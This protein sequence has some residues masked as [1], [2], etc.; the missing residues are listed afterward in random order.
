MFLKNKP[1]FYIGIGIISVFV[2]IAIFAPWIVPYS[3]S[4]IVGDSFTK[5]CLEHLLGTN[6]IGQ[7]IFSELIYGTR[8]SLLTGICATAISLLIGSTIGI[9]SGWFGGVLDDILMKITTFFI[10]IPYFPL[11]IVLSASLKGSLL[12][13]SFVLGITSWPGMARVLRSQTMKIKSSEYITTIQGM[14]AR[15]GYLVL[16]HV[17]PELVP[18]IIYHVILRCKSA[19]LSESSLSF[20]GLG[21]VVNKSWGSILYYAQAKN[22]FLTDAWIWWILPPGIMIVLLVF[23]M[24]MIEYGVEGTINQRLEEKN[25]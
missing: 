18:L 14:G 6:D 23:G 2:L 7:D 5:P 8:Y 3:P 15:D 10:T 24:M 20:L 19:I 11:V 17:L 1:Y 21:S 25:E 22:A 4:K 9:I 13:T 12:T 16:K